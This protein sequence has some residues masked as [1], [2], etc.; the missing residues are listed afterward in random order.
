MAGENCIDPLICGKNAP[1]AILLLPKYLLN[2]AVGAAGFW[3]MLLLPD[4]IVSA[5]LLL[6]LNIKFALPPTDELI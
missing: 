1:N 4:I 6:F 5:V 3:N 2:P